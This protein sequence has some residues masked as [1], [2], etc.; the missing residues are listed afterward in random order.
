MRAP[1]IGT[2][3]RALALAAGLAA[4]LGGCGIGLP[5]VAT[6]ARPATG[7]SRAPHGAAAAAGGALSASSGSAAAAVRA[8]AAAY[9]NWNAADVASRLEALA[10]TSVGRARL[11]LALEAA[12]TRDDV[13]LSRGGIANAGTVEAVVRL[14]GKGDRF[15]VITRERTT[16]TDRRGYQSLAPAWHVSLATVTLVAALARRL[17]HRRRGAQRARRGRW[18]VS[19]WQPQS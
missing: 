8:F 16:A 1:R 11:E 18:A 4:S 12:Q 3:T 19:A 10:R 14:G 6:S 5:A 13:T 17:G 7:V 2:P 15:L 9:I